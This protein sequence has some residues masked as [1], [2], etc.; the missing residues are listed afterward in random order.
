[1]TTVKRLGPTRRPMWLR[2]L[3]LPFSALLALYVL[4]APLSSFSRAQDQSPEE[5]PPWYQVEVI[6]FTQQG[7]AGEE[8]P[9]RTVQLDFPGNSLELGE[10]GETAEHNFPVAGGG[11][12][13]APT[14][15]LIPRVL[16]QD[17]ALTLAT[18]P[19]T[20]LSPEAQTAADDYDLARVNAEDA[21]YLSNNLAASQQPYTPI[22]EP[23]FIKLPREV[24]NLNESATALARQPQYKVVFHEAWRFAADQNGQDPWVIIRAGKQH[25]DRFQIEGSLRFYK[26]RFLHFQSDLWLL[27][28]DTENGNGAGNE[29]EDEDGI[30]SAATKLIELPAFPL[31]EEPS[32]SDNHIVGELQFDPAR[33]NDL[34]LDPPVS[35]GISDNQMP[36]IELAS[37]EPEQQKRPE[38][39]KKYPVSELW[40]F[41]QSK[42]IEEQQSY[43][44]D[45]PKMGIMLTIIPYQAEPINAPA[46]QTGDQTDN[47]SGN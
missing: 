12:I 13:A 37:E 5:S 3:L 34:L 43:Y 38:P 22:Y 44:I 25:Q 7:Y 4:L 14:E 1:M 36:D 2:D 33:I 21:A 30:K 47:P 16:V 46:D 42:R 18:E 45:H 17:P 31:R 39:A 27:E 40:T 23:T 9:P 29:G 10:P 32:L 15:P 11:M 8:Q 20:E 19:A 35:I 41:D 26:S 6:I 28:F 24:R